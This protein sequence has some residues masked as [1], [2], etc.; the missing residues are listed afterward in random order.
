MSRAHTHTHML[1]VNGSELEP[2]RARMWQFK[3]SV[4]STSKY[5]RYAHIKSLITLTFIL[6]QRK[7]YVMY[8]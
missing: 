3:V 4:M 1:A 6:I 2:P 8:I 5:M 7:Q